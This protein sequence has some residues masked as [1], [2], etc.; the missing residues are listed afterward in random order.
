MGGGDVGKGP[1]KKRRDLLTAE[2]RSDHHEC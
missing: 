1:M 2:P